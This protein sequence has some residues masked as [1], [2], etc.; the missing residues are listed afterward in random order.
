MFRHGLKQENFFIG[1]IMYEMT[2]LLDGRLYQIETP[3]GPFIS[4]YKRGLLFTGSLTP[5]ELTKNFSIC[6]YII[7][8]HRPETQSEDHKLDFYFFLPDGMEPELK[9][10]SKNHVI[11]KETLDIK[12]KIKIVD[13][14]GHLPVIEFT[15]ED[16]EQGEICI[17]HM[18]LKYPSIISSGCEQISSDGKE[19]WIMGKCRH[20]EIYDNTRDVFIGPNSHNIT[21]GPDCEKIYICR[22]G[23]ST[24]VGANVHYIIDSPDAGIILVDENQGEEG[25]A[26]HLKGGRDYIVR[27]SFHRGVVR[28]NGGLNDVCVIEGVEEGEFE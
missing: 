17:K 19:V 21:I 6:R 8:D 9:H 27:D 18:V 3:V 25:G 15:K 7:E 5:E 12:L 2:K 13:V 22:T 20:I 23:T 24:W 28:V 14:C 16:I 11:R 1:F 26:L 4:D 10:I